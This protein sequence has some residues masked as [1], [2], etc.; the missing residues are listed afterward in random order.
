M[1]FTIFSNEKTPFYPIKTRSSK[2]RKIDIFPRGVNPWFS[3][4][5]GH[6]S[7]FFLGSIFQ[8]NVSYDI[9]ERI[10]AFLGYTNTKFKKSK[11]WH[12]P[13][14]LTHCFRSKNGF[15]SNFFFRQY[16][17]GKWVLPYSRTKK[18]LFLAITTRSSNSGKIGIFPKGLTDGFGQ[19]MAF[20]PWFFLGNIVQE[21]VFCH[22]LERKKPPFW[23]IKARSSKGP[24]IDIFPKGLTHGFGPKMSIFPLFVLG[25]IYKESVFYHILE[26]KNAF[27]LCNDK[28]FKKSKNWSKIAVF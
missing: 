10:N 4:K 24:K 25:N 18:R 23:A 16:K 21:N 13:K 6:F 7:I 3:S 9:L 20:F 14:G 2:S 8:E 11:I 19:K 26:R 12:F 22:I 15:F 5:N 27:F 17:P 1:S 28:K